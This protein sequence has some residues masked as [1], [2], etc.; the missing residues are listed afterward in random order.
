MKKSRFTDS[1]IAEALK[2]VEAG[3]AVPE[4]CRTESS[5]NSGIKRGA[6][7]ARFSA[8]TTS[9]DCPVDQ[10]Y[11]RFGTTITIA[12]TLPYAVTAQESS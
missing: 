4:I 5:L 2:R 7:M 12:Q 9:A 10:G 11:F 6:L 8:E 1:Q 3:L